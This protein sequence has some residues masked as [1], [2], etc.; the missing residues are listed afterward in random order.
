MYKVVLKKEQLELL[1]KVRDA[2]TRIEEIKENGGNVEIYISEDKIEDLMDD[3]SLD[4]ADY[5]M[6]DA[7]EWLNKFGIQLTAL[8]DEIQYQVKNNN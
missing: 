5:G 6:D 4:V 8:Y 7:Q 3:I 1:K 2:L